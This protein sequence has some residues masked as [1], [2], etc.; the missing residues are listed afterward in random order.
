M[1]SFYDA[2]KKHQLIIY[3]NIQEMRPKKSVFNIVALLFF[4]SV[5]G[6]LQARVP[7][8][9]YSQ[10]L[11]AFSR[12]ACED[13]AL[14]DYNRG[15]IRALNYT[16]QRALRAFSKLECISAAELVAAL[17]RLV[18]EEIAFDNLLL[19]LNSKLL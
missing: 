6:S 2:I 15:L 7:D 17:R 19:L 4:L 14:F 10:T 5:P 12:V 9:G 1:K 11:E 3:L 13:E 8:K 18:A 16:N